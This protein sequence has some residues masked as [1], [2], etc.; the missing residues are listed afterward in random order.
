MIVDA[1]TKKHGKG[2]SHV[3]LPH[4]RSVSAT[5]LQFRKVHGRD[6]RPHR[7]H[8]GTSSGPVGY[9]N[10]DML[11]VARRPYRVTQNSRPT[12]RRHIIRASFEDT[13]DI[14]MRSAFLEL[15]VL[16]LQKSRVL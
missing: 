5:R 7:Q 8:E 14:D 15:L 6:L 3:E 9:G 1:L 13:I 16:S 10:D 12:C 2:V 4:E 11:L